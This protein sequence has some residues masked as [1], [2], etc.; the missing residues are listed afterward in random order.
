MVTIGAVLAVNAVPSNLDIRRALNKLSSAATIG[1][2]DG[3]SARVGTHYCGGTLHS[4][5]L[6]HFI[7]LIRSSPLDSLLGITT[8]INRQRT[9]WQN[10]LIGGK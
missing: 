3:G 1:R 5:Y 2:D 6:A 10:V 7:D 4:S 9:Q 8:L